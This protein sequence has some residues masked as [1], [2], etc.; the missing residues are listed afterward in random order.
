MAKL[1]NRPMPR[2]SIKHYQAV[3]KQVISLHGVV[4]KAIAATGISDHA[5]ARLMRDGELVF[6][7]AKKI[8]AAYSA[9]NIQEVA[10]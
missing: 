5:Y 2:T 1:D 3:M 6:S 10:A 4:N 9:S 8:M 7:V